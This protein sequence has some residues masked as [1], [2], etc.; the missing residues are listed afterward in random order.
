MHILWTYLRPHSRLAWLALLLAAISQVLALVDPIIF[1]KIIDG[2]AIN[3]GNKTDDELI[4]GVL[5]LLGLAVAVAIGSRLAKALQEYVTRL[6]VQKLGTQLFNDGLRQVM[7]LKYQEFAEMR[8]GE[9]LSLLQKARADSERFINTFINT[10]FAALVGISFLVWYSVTRHWA[11]VP[12]FLIGVLVLGGLTGLL[13]REIRNQQRSIV[14]ETN[15]NSGFITESLRNIELI[16][17]LGLTFPEVRRLQAQTEKIFALEMQKVKRIRLLSFLQGS[18]L[19]LL[20]L[21]ILFALLWLIFRDVL[22]TGE[23]IA[24]QFISVAIFAPLQELGNIIIAWREAEASLKNFSALMNKPI[25]KRPANP[26]RVGL[27]Q[28][29]NF[30]QVEFQ[31]RG[32]EDKALDGVSFSAKLG[33]TIAFVGPSGS[34]KS[35]LVKLLVGL[36]TPQAGSIDFN[37]IPTQQLRYNEVRRQIGFVTQETHLFAG[38]LRENMLF[39]KPDAT[40]EEILRAMEQASCLHL[41]ARSPLGLDTPIGE[42]GV[43]LSGGEK[44]RLSIARALVRDPRLLI[45]DEATSALDSLTEEQITA[46]VRQVSQQSHRITLLI[47]HR[48]STI[49]HAQTIIVLERGRI[50]ESGSHAELLERKGLYYAMW[51]QQIGERPAGP[52]LGALPP[53]ED[54]LEPAAGN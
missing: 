41:L 26:Q 31:H 34:G 8:T 19:S 5:R 37:G 47:A 28:A 3:P 35:T 33:D 42:S 7:R 21:G 12:V 45:F 48:L 49:L 23:L 15:R 43:R 20:K 13:S 54:A 52:P 46:T 14:R 36:Y 11:L 16:K 17:S 53:Q 9:T 18:T 6:V 10:V 1:G 38:T 4:S 25:E 39:V 44:Q 51:R 24:M 22:S 32:A 27:L 40:D 2:Y 29:L 50:A 30:N